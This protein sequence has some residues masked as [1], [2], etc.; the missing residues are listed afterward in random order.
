MIQTVQIGPI[1][2]IKLAELLHAPSVSRVVVLADEN[3]VRECLPLVE[4]HLPAGYRLVEMP[5]GEEYKTLETCQLLWAEL[6][7]LRADRYAVVVNLGG[8][9]VTDLGGFAAAVYKRGVRFAQVPTTLLAQVDASVGGKTGVD[10]MG[11]KNQLGVFQQAAAVCIE[12]RFLRTLDPRQLKSGYAE[13]V[14]H[15]L[16]A[17]A[18]AFER[19]RYVGIMVDDWTPVIEESVALKQRIVE[20]DPLETGLRKLLNFGHTVGHALESYLLQQPG[21]E[22]L[23]GEAVAAGMVCEAWLSH[24]KG[25]LSAAELDK[26]ETFLFSIFEKVQYVLLETEAI[27]DYALQDK[28]NTGSIINCTLLE[29]IGRGVYDQPVTLA[30]VSEA[31]RYYH[32]LPG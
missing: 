8:G 29:G 5:A 28:K 19:N 15:W 17:D 11:F 18:G 26:I 25:L 13:V 16:I 3:T 7:E 10:F 20:Q 9:V 27:A 22:I 2:L 4:P 21:R 14:K 6:T 30:E 12:P 23:H 32:R 24:H 1:A 31:L